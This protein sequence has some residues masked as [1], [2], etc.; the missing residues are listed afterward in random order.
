MR[1]RTLA[2]ASV[3][4]SRK[5]HGTRMRYMAGCKCLL[6][7]AAN[8]NYET[9]RA[10]RRRQGLWNGLVSAR[11]A[12]RHIL[13]LSEKGVGRATV[14]KVA[15]ISRTVIV[16]IRSGQRKRIRALTEKAIL[17]VTPHDARGKTLVP[18]EKTWKLIDW[19]LSEGFTEARLAREL[20]YK[21]RSIQFNANLV[22]AANA[23]KVEELYS[24]Y[25]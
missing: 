13:R 20:G 3:L 15:H 25:Q 19:F 4:G 8:S 11:R 9:M 5:P 18:A 2:P 24:R 1:P 23:K 16:K 17:L 21:N 12:R 22:T 10:R 6:C 14:S 7:R